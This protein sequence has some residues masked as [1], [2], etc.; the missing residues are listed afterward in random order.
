VIDIHRFLGCS[1]ISAVI[2]DERGVSYSDKIMKCWEA[3]NNFF[4][5]IRF[6]KLD[7]FFNVRF[8]IS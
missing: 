1:V 4:L 8:V 5:R 2:S 7:Y 6:Q 3:L